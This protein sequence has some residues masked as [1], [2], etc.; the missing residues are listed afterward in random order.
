MKVAKMD[1]LCF[2]SSAVAQ[3]QQTILGAKVNFIF[4]RSLIFL[5][6]FFVYSTY[7]VSVTKIRKRVEKVRE[8]VRSPPSTAAIIT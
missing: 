7:C 6:C 4:I 5:S 1:E 2:S 8:T 3:Q